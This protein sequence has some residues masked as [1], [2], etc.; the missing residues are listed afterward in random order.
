ML[1]LLNREE[2]SRRVAEVLAGG[3]LMSTVNL[4]EVVA[5]LADIGMP[6]REIHEALDPLGLEFVAFEARD[7]FAAG[8]LRPDT[9]AAGLSLG[10]RCCLALGR[11]SG[12]PILTADRRWEGLDLGPGLRIELIR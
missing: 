3:V 2:G 1:A 10:D 4:S 9:S 7:A 8:V 11:L 6:E 5:K 12:L